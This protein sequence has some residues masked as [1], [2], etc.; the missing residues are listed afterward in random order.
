MDKLW[1]ELWRIINILLAGLSLYFL[2]FIISPDYKV[3]IRPNFYRH[4]DYCPK[5][6]WDEVCWGAALNKINQLK[7]DK[8]ISRAKMVIGNLKGETESHAWII[9]VKNGKTIGFEPMTGKEI[10]KWEE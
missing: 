5:I 2:F 4:L 6:F 3:L 10:N 9:Y 8:E 7:Q 1:R